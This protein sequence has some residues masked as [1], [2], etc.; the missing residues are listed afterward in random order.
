MVGFMCFLLRLTKKF[1]LQNKYG[2]RMLLFFSFLFY[3]FSFIGRCLSFFFL[4]PIRCFCFSFF[5]P[6]HCLSFFS[7]FF[8]WFPRQAS[9]S[10]TST[11]LH[12]L[13]SFFFFFFFSFL[14][15][16]F[17]IINLGDFFGH[18]LVLIGHCFLI[19]VHK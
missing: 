11:L 18:F 2:L 5:F 19:R 15:T 16:I 4:F 8:F 9:S 6:R 14:D 10:M 13:L 7:S 1:S 17:F 3:F 12:A